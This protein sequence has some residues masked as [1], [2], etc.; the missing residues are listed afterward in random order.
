[1]NGASTIT[2]SLV[3]EHLLLRGLYN[4]LKAFDQDSKSGKDLKLQVDKF[5]GD[6][7]AAVDNLDIDIL[8][9]I[10]DLWKSKVFNSLSG[11][12]RTIQNPK[13][14]KR[15]GNIISAPRSHLV[16]LVE[17]L[18]EE[19]EQGHLADRSHAMNCGMMNPFEDELMDDFAVIAQCSGTMKMSASKPSLKTF[20]KNLTSGNRKSNVES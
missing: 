13:D 6:T 18:T 4:A 9:S 14:A 16:Q 5:V 19:M 3:R 10:W 20:F 11:H 8:K 1:M 2:D 7:L 17:L 15:I 12:S